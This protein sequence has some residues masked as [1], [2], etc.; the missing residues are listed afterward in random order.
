MARV[1]AMHL[2]RARPL[3][4]GGGAGLDPGLRADADRRAR[5]TYSV[6]DSLSPSLSLSRTLRVHHAFMRIRCAASAPGQPRHT[7]PRGKRCFLQPTGSGQPTK[8]PP[9][10]GKE[11]KGYFCNGSFRPIN[12]LV[13]LNEPGEAS[14]GTVMRDVLCWD[15][16]GRHGTATGE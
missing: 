16:T 9:I 6:Y 15:G 14:P 1:V 2:Q 5:S 12:K 7:K 11:R 8:P 10:R 4:E 3:M 13:S